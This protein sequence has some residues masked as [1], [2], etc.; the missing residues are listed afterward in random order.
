MY[1]QRY[2]MFDAISDA[3]PL[4]LSDARRLSFEAI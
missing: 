3:L 2:A 1:K 4:E